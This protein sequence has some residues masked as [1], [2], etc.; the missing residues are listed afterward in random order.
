MESTIPSTQE[1]Y[2]KWRVT[3]KCSG[4]LIYTI[5]T[6]SVQ[7]TEHDTDT[8]HNTDQKDYDMLTTGIVM[9]I[10]FMSHD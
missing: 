2:F 8:L 6:E 1:I 10:D 9:A 5:Y 4:D 7:Y 3:N